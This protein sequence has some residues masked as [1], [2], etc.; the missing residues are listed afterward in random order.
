M[1]S[2]SGDAK[3][4]RVDDQQ[5]DV[6]GRFA[7][8]LSARGVTLG[9]VSVRDVPGAGRGVFADGPIR[10]GDA[11]A[12]V[13][14]S[15]VLSEAYAWSTPHGQA[16]RS[17]SDVLGEVHGRT[18]VVLSMVGARAD[19]SSELHAWMASLP[20]TYDTPLWWGADERA[21]LAHSPVG[22]REAERE[23]QMR[24]TFD[25]IVP[26]LR[27][28]FP[29][30]FSAAA[31]TWERF[32]WAHSAYHSRCLPERL[33]LG[34]AEAH[35]QAGCLVPFH[36]MYNHVKGAPTRWDISDDRVT[37]RA[38]RDI[39]G[40]APVCIDYGVRSNAM[41]LMT[42]GFCVPNNAA[43]TVDMTI[44]V[45]SRDEGSYRARMALLARHG[46]SNRVTIR[47]RSGPRTKGESKEE[48]RVGKTEAVS[49]SSWETEAVSSSSS[50]S[51]SSTNSPSAG[52]VGATGDVSISEEY[53]GILWAARIAALDDHEL[54]LIYR[55]RSNG[56]GDGVEEGCDVRPVPWV[57]ARNEGCA[58][59]LLAHS[60]E[61]N[62]R[63][64]ESRAGDRATA[65]AAATTAAA[66][67]TPV[68]AKE[69]VCPYRLQCASLYLEGR[70]EVLLGA[71]DA[72]SEARASLYSGQR[73]KDG[74]T[75][76]GDGIDR[77]GK[78]GAAEVD[79]C[80]AAHWGC[81]GGNNGV[82]FARGDATMRATKHVPLG[83]VVVRVRFD[84]LISA[85]RVLSSSSFGAGL[86]QVGGLDDTLVLQLYLMH[87]LASRGEQN[88]QSCSGPAAIPS[89]ST[90][91]AATAAVAA[92]ADDTGGDTGGSS[93][94]L[95][96]GSL[97]A[98][99]DGFLECATGSVADAALFWTT[100]EFAAL[101][102][103]CAGEVQGA[104]E[105]LRDDMA[106]DYGGLFPALSDAL[107]AMFPASRFTLEAFIHAALLMEGGRTIVSDD[108]SYFLACGATIEPHHAAPNVGPFLLNTASRHVE[109]HALKAVANGDNLRMFVG[110]SAELA[111]NVELLVRQGV[112]MAGCN[113]VD[114]IS[115]S[116]AAAGDVDLRAAD[117]H[118][119]KLW[120]VFSEGSEGS[121]GSEQSEQI[122]GG[123]KSP[124]ARLGVVGNDVDAVRGLQTGL[125]EVLGDFG[126]AA[127]GGG[128]AGEGVKGAGVRRRAL[129]KAFVA[130]R[131]AL[132]DDLLD[133]LV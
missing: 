14:T 108:T 95:V 10:A 89:A 58:L 49:S 60:I 104:V 32:L 26:P 18:V 114:C 85:E 2:S 1:A 101:G 118:T 56:G 106:E 121:K 46:L 59:A 117:V 24:E 100:E 6:W 119:A 74:E 28:R 99:V 4:R 8:T 17:A 12:S 42:Y 77:H 80:M 127:R 112:V 128:G 29:A 131:A 19:A 86:A 102:P 90:A 47:Q 113:P 125:R 62:I 65:L 44:G 37:L 57:S 120:D 40:G 72:V 64:E 109:C 69:D 52:S 61:E 75:E 132:C 71:R 115:L 16:V 11:I 51:S 87:R 97:D 93:D 68:T 98:L 110:A 123:G 103:A 3:R 67:T 70:R 54:Q 111:D 50:S 88:D 105:G 43:D 63:F 38:S 55:L 81:V 133:A 13:P 21:A 84:A 5:P 124:G 15:L 34:H 23:P 107:P 48:T 30:L 41:L 45:A 39:P 7:S 53:R 129:A 122:G 27:S 25:R 126:Q 92:S 94:S 31:F 76:G 36:D 79:A 91:S 78:A 83:G 20:E 82:A 22:E 9:S 66:A 116:T 96:D 33:I 130:A 35:A 73:R